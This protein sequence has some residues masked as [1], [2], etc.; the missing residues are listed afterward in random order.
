MLDDF[1]CSKSALKVPRAQGKARALEKPPTVYVRTG[2]AGLI[3]STIQT[4][5][6]IRFSLRALRNKW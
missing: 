1:K 2:V 6:A 5:E 3:V 4:S